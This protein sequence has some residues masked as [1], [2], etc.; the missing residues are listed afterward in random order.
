MTISIVSCILR[1]HATIKIFIRGLKNY[2]KKVL[3]SFYFT[4]TVIILQIVNSLTLPLI[5]NVDQPANPK[6]VFSKNEDVDKHAGGG[7]N[8]PNLP[9]RPADQL[10]TNLD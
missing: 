3:R 2:C 5:A 4:L 10:M 1:W 7:L 9:V 8:H 6:P